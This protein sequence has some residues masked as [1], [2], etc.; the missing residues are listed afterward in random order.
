MMTSY[1]EDG[2]HSLSVEIR[3]LESILNNSINN[4]FDKVVK[5]LLN[6]KGR[7]ILSG[8]GKTGYLARRD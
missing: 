5:T 2:K 7:V 8:V 1:I 4:T 6:T 3:G